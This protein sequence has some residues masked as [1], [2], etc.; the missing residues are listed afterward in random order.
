ME[1]RICSVA[2]PDADRAY[3]DLPSG[4][5]A[6]TRP[7]VIRRSS[8]DRPWGHQKNIP[9]ANVAPFVHSKSGL[10]PAV[11]EMSDSQQPPSMESPAHDASQPKSDDSKTELDETKPMSPGGPTTKS[12]SH[13][14]RHA[15][16]SSGSESK[17][18]KE[19]RS[20]AM[21][22]SSHLLKRLARIDKSKRKSYELDELGVHNV[23]LKYKVLKSSR[24][25]M[26]RVQ[27]DKPLQ[28]H[29]TKAC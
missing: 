15:K 27:P 10:D 6:I 4:T 14:P 21:K 22:K 29:Q 9:V 7:E 12:P 2:G 3:A 18:S 16:E 20:K 24:L 17:R 19:H 8:L 13:R 28:V 23:P 1:G 25:T 11:R 26:Q 5:G